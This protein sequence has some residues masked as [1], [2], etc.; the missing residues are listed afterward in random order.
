MSPLYRASLVS[1]VVALACALAASPA[2]AAVSATPAS[3]SWVTNGTVYSS[4]TDADGNVFIGG[5]FTSVG[6]R[7]GAGIALTSTDGQYDAAYPEVAGGYIQAVEPDG[8]GGWFLGGSF[9]SVGGVARSGLAHITAD[10]AVDPDW[11]PGINANG[12]VLGLELG[13]GALYAWGNFSTVGGVARSNLA[14]LAPATGAVDPAW[15]PNPSDSSIYALAADASGVYL[16]GGFISIA[17]HSYRTTGL[18]KL[19]ASNATF[20]DAWNPQTGMFNYVYAMELVG[21]NVIM[22]G[23]FTSIDGAA[24]QRLARVS[25]SGVVDNGWNPSLSTSSADMAV[26]GDSLYVAT[27]PTVKKVSLTTGATDSGFNPAL[28]GGQYGPQIFGLAASGSDLYVAGGFSAIGGVPV[29]NV[30]KLSAAT[31][32]ADAGWRPNPNTRATTVGAAGSRVYAGGGFSSAG[33]GVAPRGGVAKLSRTGELDPDWNPGTNG[34]VRKVLV[35]GADVY[36]GGSFTTAGGA[37]RARLAKFSRTGAG[38][39]DPQFAPNPGG[40]V[41]ALAVADGALY[42]GGS[43]TSIGGRSASRLAK[44]STATGAADAA[45]LPNPN[46]TVNALEPS[47]SGLYVGG[48]FTSIGGVSTTAVARLSTTDAGAADPAWKPNPAG[49]AYGNQVYAIARSGDDV[50]LGGMFATVG[51]QPHTNLAKVSALGAGAA[52]ASWGANPDDTYYGSVQALALAGDDLYV[53]GR[54]ITVGG[55][56]IR[57]LAKVSANGA[58]SVDAAWKPEP[59][60]YVYSL[61]SA[62]AGLYAGG[63]FTGLGNVAAASFALLPAIDTTAPETTDDVPAGYRPAPVAVTL[64]ATDAGSG[65]AATYFTTGASPAQPTTASTVYDAGDKP[66]LAGGEA[67]RYFSV[68]EAGNAETPRTSAAAQVDTDA[69]ETAADV[70]SGYRAGPVTVTLTATDA[71][72]GV[73]ATYYTTGAAPATPTT[74]SAVY[75]EGA[76]PVLADGE[77]ISFF[78]VDAVGNAG[79]PVTSTAAKVDMVAP[80]TA[81]D[82]PAGEQPGSV[83]VTLAATD[84]GSGVSA[85]YYTT[86]AEPALPTTASTVYDASAKPT[87]AAGERIRYFSVDAVGNAEAPHVSGALEV[88][89]PPTGGTTPPAVTPPAEA[90]PAGP[91]MMPGTGGAPATISGKLDGGTYSVEA[92]G[93]GSFTLD[94]TGVGTL[95]VGRTLTVVLAGG[96][97]TLTPE[98]GAA[99]VLAGRAGAGPGRIGVEITATGVTYTLADPGAKRIRMGATV[100]RVPGETTVRVAGGAA[101]FDVQGT[102]RCFVALD[103]ARTNRFTAAPGIR[104]TIRQAKP[105]GRERSTAHDVIRTGGRADR[106]AAGTGDDRVFAGAGGDRIRAGHGE[107]RVRAGAGDDIVRVRGGGFDAVRCGA[108]EDVAHADRGDRVAADCE[109]VVRR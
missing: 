95:H 83:S 58:G 22:S 84:G 63:T 29:D 62:P 85:T 88:T 51:G 38:A 13:G 89:V 82:V 17:G 60:G 72:S 3:T 27:S 64:T 65:V 55:E 4:A 91:T 20:D 5:D 102:G 101:W 28:T 52:D 41:L 56:S 79:T 8:A 15:A 47:A 10:G 2:G 93:P 66:V 24:H 71:G 40:D 26:S 34:V 44:L 68:D 16:S 53:G 98:G 57:N 105:A 90:A 81:D 30:A 50:Y 33:S 48:G 23:G 32:A 7:T 46:N 54:F 107:D 49:G 73:A 14:K 87:L 35:S 106:I 25:T 43:F 75:D 12:Q 19:S 70:P 67:I 86:G 45:W 18:Y 1:V 39:V 108:G 69:P 31:G 94:L 61:T 109:R 77:K 21:S 78:S 96:T 6:P 104:C 59:N 97:V 103:P 100:A 42:A 36:A 80:V 99:I 9:Q 74:A 76:K 92:P 37:P 11:N